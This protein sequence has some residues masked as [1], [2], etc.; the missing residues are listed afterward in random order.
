MFRDFLGY[1]PMESVNFMCAGLHIGSGVW[2]GG[3]KAFSKGERSFVQG[4]IPAM[5]MKETFRGK[6]G[7][8]CM[9]QVMWD[10]VADLLE[11][12]HWCASF[13]QVS[14]K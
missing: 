8:E 11:V 6:V 1:S 12:G 9:V 4:L 5:L 10:A 7:L 3:P 2:G 13:I 14:T